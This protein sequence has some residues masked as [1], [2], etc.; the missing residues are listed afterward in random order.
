MTQRRGLVSAIAVIVLC[1]AV[2]HAQAPRRPTIY[3]ITATLSRPSGAPGEIVTQGATWSC[4]NS[5]C[6]TRSLSPSVVIA[7]CAALAAR[8]GQ[9]SAYG[10]SGAM[11]TAEQ[12]A[13]CNRSARVQAQAQPQVRLPPNV[14]LPRGAVV[15]PGQGASSPNN[16]PAPAVAESP[17]GTRTAQLT[18]TGTGALAP[19]TPFSAASIRTAPLAVTGTGALAATAPFAAV[20]VRTAPLTVTGAEP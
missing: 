7:T 10:R 8:V 15:R 19:S 3:E 18:V 17:T 14:A 4:T 6:T 11:L 9:I 16:A 20:S 1:S 12:L 5:A 2:A 13:E